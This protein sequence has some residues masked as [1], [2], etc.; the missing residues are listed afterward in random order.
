[1]SPKKN[2]GPISKEVRNLVRD[3]LKCAINDNQ[4]KQ[5]LLGVLDKCSAQGIGLALASWDP[6]YLYLLTDNV[7]REIAT[8]VQLEESDWAIA[9]GRWGQ[10]KL[11]GDEEIKKM[12]GDC[13]QSPLNKTVFEQRL[14]DWIYKHAGQPGYKK[15]LREELVGALLDFF[16]S[17]ADE[18]NSGIRRGFKKFVGIMSK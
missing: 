3:R 14:R 10:G 15:Y 6:H 4:F 16:F 11:R 18:V 1:M 9:M 2:I 13:L 5:G 17:L 12:L 8:W 7:D